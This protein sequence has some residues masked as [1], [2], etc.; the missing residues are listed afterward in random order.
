MFDPIHSGHLNCAEQAIGRFDLDKV[1]FIPSA[2]PPHK[3][4]T[5]ASGEE[6]FEMAK[7]ALADYPAFEVS[8]AE[9]DRDTGVSYTVDTVLEFRKR[10]GDEIYFIIGMDAFSDISSWRSPG[11][12]FMNCNFTV[13]GR[14]GWDAK[15]TIAKIEEGLGRVGKGPFFKVLEDGVSYSFI[16]SPYSVFF[17]AV[18][19]LDISSSQAR[20][21]IM[22]G[23]PVADILPEGVA[24]YIKE[25]GLYV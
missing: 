13:I 12:I 3:R 2:L 25:K 20:E 24:K 10:Y 17:Y 7:I 19:E 1:F 14:P 18:K 6:R 23:E 9:L 5:S 22:K 15:G 16:G 11:E 4:V 21:R 8:R